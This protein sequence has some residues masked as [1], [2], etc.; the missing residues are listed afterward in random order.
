MTGAA[1]EIQGG[2]AEI[3]TCCAIHPDNKLVVTGS[4]DRKLKIW[5]VDNEQSLSTMSG[6]ARGDIESCAF[7]PDG[8]W[9]LSLGGDFRVWD[10]DTGTQKFL[11]AG[12]EAYGGPLGTCQIEPFGHWVLKIGKFKL[13]L[14]KAE[15]DSSHKRQELLGYTK[16]NFDFSISPDGSWIITAGA[17]HRL[18][19]YNAINGRLIKGLKGHQQTV[20]SCKVSQ[21]GRFLISASSDR[22]FKIWDLQ[23]FKLLSTIQ[24]EID[25]PIVTIDPRI[26]AISPDGSFFVSNFWYDLTIWDIS[27][28]NVRAK[29]ENSGSSCVI[30]PDGRWIVSLK[31]MLKIWDSNSGK[32]AAELPLE[33]QGTQLS[34][35]PFE[36][37][38]ACGKSGNLYLFDLIGIEFGAM[39]VTVFNEGKDMLVRCPVCQSTFAIQ[40]EWLGTMITCPRPDCMIQLKINKHVLCKA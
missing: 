30:S 35:H 33:G 40:K 23:T 25:S 26:A 27:T 20:T 34:I 24:S 12:H 9:I 13:R 37:R 11:L 10:V 16:R 21:D 38:L 19:V 15:V 4:A 31:D 3:L 5:N 22:T 7:S 39:I 2:H 17:D 32:L 14:W 29:L 8:K 1:D 18:K 6:H 28:G 36:P